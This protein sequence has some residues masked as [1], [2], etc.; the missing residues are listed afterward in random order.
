MKPQ[1]IMV[2]QNDGQ[3]TPW[4]SSEDRWSRKAKHPMNLPSKTSIEN[5]WERGDLAI[6]EGKE[7]TIAVPQG[8]NS[9]VGVLINGKTRMVLE[10]KLS[11]IDEGVIGGLQPLSPINRMMQ[12][13]GISVP[14][15]IGEEMEIMEAD[16]TNMFNGLFKAN[17][18]GEFKN[19]PEA[20]RLATIG[21]IMVGLESQAEELRGK[22]SQDLEKKINTVVGLGASLMSAARTMLKPSPAGE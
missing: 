8:P 13:A 9:T 1:S 19:N 10:S 18:V 5:D 3:E 2:E 16:T 21:Q 6:Y 7:V 22:V 15:V 20:A 14:T 11:R 12:L 4:N 17:M